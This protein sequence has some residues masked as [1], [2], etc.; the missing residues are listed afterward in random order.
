MFYMKLFWLFK[1]CY[2]VMFIPGELAGFEQ[3]WKDRKGNVKVQLPGW[4]D[5]FGMHGDAGKHII[6]F[7]LL[8]CLLELNL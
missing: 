2:V 5:G 3:A 4:E 1:Q 7:S 6:G 8:V